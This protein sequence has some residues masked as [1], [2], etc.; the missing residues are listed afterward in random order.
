MDINPF[1]KKRTK[2]HSL[3]VNGNKKRERMRK[4]G[5][6]SAGEVVSERGKIYKQMGDKEKK[7][8]KE[9]RIKKKKEIKRERETER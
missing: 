3:S 9:A 5:T 6:W 1:I 4:G 2:S 7:G 8:E